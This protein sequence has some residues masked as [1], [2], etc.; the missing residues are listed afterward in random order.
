[1]RNAVGTLKFHLQGKKKYEPKVIL[2]YCK[3]W[4]VG[5]SPS[6]EAPPFTLM[7]DRGTTFPAWAS[8]FRALHGP[9]VALMLS[10]SASSGNTHLMNAVLV[11]S[12]KTEGPALFTG[13]ETEC[14]LTRTDVVASLVWSHITLNC[15]D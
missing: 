3:Q 6:Q 15:N 8:T 12:G 9:Q 7:K 4:R 14:A 10:Y 1:M 11:P 13:E 2:S 5:R